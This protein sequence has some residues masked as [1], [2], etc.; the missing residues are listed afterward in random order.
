M[1]KSWSELGTG[2]RTAIVVAA[3]LEGALKIAAL[4]DLARRPA[5]KVHGSKAAWAVGIAAVNGFGIAPLS[6]FACHGM[7]T[8]PVCKGGECR[9]GA[10]RSGQGRCPLFR[11]DSIFVRA[12][13]AVA[14]SVGTAGQ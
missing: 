14:E 1:S 3:S 13:E 12:H 8:C 2:M 11:P 9:C 6:Y 4:V 10:R 5:E 7:L